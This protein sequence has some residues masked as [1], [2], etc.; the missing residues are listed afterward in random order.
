MDQYL[1]ITLSWFQQLGITKI[2]ED[3]LKRQLSIISSWFKNNGIGVLEA[4]TGLTFK[5]LNFIFTA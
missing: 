3:K 4:V 1:E 2:D 5:N